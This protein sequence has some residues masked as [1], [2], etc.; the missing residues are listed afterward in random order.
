MDADGRGQSIVTMD[1]FN[2]LGDRFKERMTC[3]GI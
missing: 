3:E 2:E 1:T